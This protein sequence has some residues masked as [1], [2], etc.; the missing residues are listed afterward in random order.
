MRTPSFRINT[1]DSRASFEASVVKLLRN[2]RSANQ[3]HVILCRL[4]W[5]S[6]GPPLQMQQQHNSLFASASS[7]RS[8]CFRYSVLIFHFL[9]RFRAFR[10]RLARRP[11]PPR[12]WNTVACSRVG[13]LLILQIQLL[14]SISAATSQSTRRTDSFPKIEYFV[15][16]RRRVARSAVEHRNS[17]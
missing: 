4:R 17:R 8:F 11:R 3:R 16:N 6:R 9:Y 2:C 7:L 12:T 10:P 5:R 15:R 1:R 14:E 13:F